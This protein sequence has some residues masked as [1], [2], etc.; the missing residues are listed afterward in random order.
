MVFPEGA[1]LLA[2]GTVSHITEQLVVIQSLPNMPAVDEGTVLWSGEKK[3]L[4]VVC[5][6]V[7]PCW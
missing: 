5:W 7:W 1:Q 4:S 3:S 2:L 6:C